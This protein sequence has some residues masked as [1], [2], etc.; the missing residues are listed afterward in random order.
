MIRKSAVFHAALPLPA[1]FGANGFFA[2]PVPPA[3]R[4][5]RAGTFVPMQHPGAVPGLHAE[6][7]G[8]FPA[9]AGMAARGGRRA[10]RAVS[11]SEINPVSSCK[12]DSINPATG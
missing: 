1:I 5:R 7:A 10:I 2:A 12:V 6:S 4:T 8:I 9:T 3:N 11:D